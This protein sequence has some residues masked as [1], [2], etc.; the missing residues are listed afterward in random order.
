MLKSLE[1]V[2]KAN[3]IP[4]LRLAT[5][6]EGK[7][8]ESTGPHK[9]KIIGDEVIKDKDFSGNEIFKVRYTLEENGVK[10]RYDVAVKND[11]G[12][13]SYLVQ[14]LA[15]IPEGTEITLEYVRKGLKGYIDVRTQ[16]EEIAKD[17]E[18][19]MPVIQ[20]KEELAFDDDGN[21]IPL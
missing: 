3:I 19:E 21:V 6:K 7:G 1:L 9:V 18:S 10:K 5:K 16:A 15:D 20:E 8:T 2:Q 12:E 4:F 14:K 11:K 13:L 17:S